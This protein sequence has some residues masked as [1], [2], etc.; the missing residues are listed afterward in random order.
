MAA[1]DGV[2]HL[3]AAI[4]KG[5][6]LQWA[7]DAATLMGP[8][9]DEIDRSA[10]ELPSPDGSDDEDIDSDESDETGEAT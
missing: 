10:L 8:D 3:T 7:V 4:C 5:K 6:A 1:N 9:G 2:A